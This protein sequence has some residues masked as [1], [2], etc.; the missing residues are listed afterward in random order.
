[1]NRTAAFALAV[2]LAAADA[3]AF[4]AEGTYVVHGTGQSPCSEW[5]VDRM[6]AG[7]GVWQL[8]QWVLG[9]LSAYNAL[10]RGSA[11]I[12]GELGA[13]GLFAWLDD[14]CGGAQATVLS[15]AVQDFIRERRAIQER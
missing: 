8:Q 12:A 4:D 13:E 1:M 10:T 9:Y 3:A 7:T 15:V 14:Y 11:D 5:S 6:V 2:C